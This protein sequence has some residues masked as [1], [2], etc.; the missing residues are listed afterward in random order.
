MSQMID[1]KLDLE[2]IL[3]QRGWG[4]HNAGVAHEDIETVM[5]ESLHHAILDGLKRTHVQLDECQVDGGVSRLDV[6]DQ[7]ISG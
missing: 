7:G 2:T 1:G 3:A 6:A 4:G 5:H